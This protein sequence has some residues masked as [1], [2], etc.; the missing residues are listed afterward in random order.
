MPATPLSNSKSLNQDCSS[1]ACNHNIIALKLKCLHVS[2]FVVSKLKRRQG[3]W[4]RSLVGVP[5]E[6]IVPAAFFAYLRRTI[7]PA[8]PTNISAHDAGSGTAKV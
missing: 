3:K 4:L 6:E 8:R 7:N 5:A 2:V 1:N